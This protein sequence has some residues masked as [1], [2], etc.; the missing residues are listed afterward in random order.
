MC[1]PRG[2]STTLSPGNRNSLHAIRKPTHF[3]P[4]IAAAVFALGVAVLSMACVSA[5]FGTLTPQALPEV[6]AAQLAP[7]IDTGHT[8]PV[9]S[10]QLETLDQSR[11][12]AALEK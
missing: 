3:S 7:D 9:Q 10:E 6:E 8:S 2:N 11:L 4:A 12:A 1:T 5:Q